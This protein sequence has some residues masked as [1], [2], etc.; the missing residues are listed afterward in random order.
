MP[1][2]SSPRACFT[3]APNTV[4]F[5]PSHYR[6]ALAQTEIHTQPEIPLT[7]YVPGAA[8]VERLIARG[9]RATYQALKSLSKAQAA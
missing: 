8:A 9:E 3:S 7:G 4:E 5:S 1:P 2:G 6:F